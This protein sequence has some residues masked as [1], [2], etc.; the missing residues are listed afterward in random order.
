[1]VSF[2]DIYTNMEIYTLRYPIAIPNQPL[3]ALSIFET[4]AIYSG[5]VCPTKATSVNEEYG[6]YFRC[7]YKRRC[8]R[9]CDAQKSPSVSPATHR[10]LYSI[11]EQRAV[12]ASERIRWDFIV[13]TVCEYYFI[14]LSDVVI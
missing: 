3:I 2:Y 1:M 9:C 10:P 4:A 8:Y 7:I 6:K 14:L 5:D 11:I 13:N 12:F